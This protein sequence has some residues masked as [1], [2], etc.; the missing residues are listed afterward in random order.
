M[1]VCSAA[2]SVAA[3]RLG[4]P[5]RVAAGDDARRRRDGVDAAVVRLGGDGLGAQ[6]LGKRERDFFAFRLCVCVCVF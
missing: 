3:A 5:R 1:H 4:A 6:L 2:A